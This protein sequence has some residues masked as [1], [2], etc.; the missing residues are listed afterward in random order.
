[1]GSVF[2]AIILLWGVMNLLTTLTADKPSASD[3]AESASAMDRDA[4]AQAAAVAVALALAEE[5][6]ARARPLSEPP[7]TIV[8]AWQLGM[9]TNQ[10]YEKRAPTIHKPRKAR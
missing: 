2:A 8:S 1:M 4:K 3:S 5:Q 6:T 9:R 7:T 10:L